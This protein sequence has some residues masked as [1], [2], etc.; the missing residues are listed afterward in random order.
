MSERS[1]RQR[2]EALEH[3]ILQQR[4]EMTAAMREWR[5]ATAPID[6]AWDKLMSWRV[7]LM[8][9]GSLFALRSA[10]KPRATGRMLRR[11]L[12]GL[13]MYNRGKALYRATRGRRR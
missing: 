9:A 10:R 6:N 2:I 3:E 4:L 1:H 11:A 7:P 12:T 5:D 8:A 13:M